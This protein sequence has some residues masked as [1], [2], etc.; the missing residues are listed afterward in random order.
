M[1]RFVYL[2]PLP[3]PPPANFHSTQQVA[4]GTQ[5][6]NSFRKNHLCSGNTP[7]RHIPDFNRRAR[8]DL[9]SCRTTPSTVTPRT[10]PR[11]N[12]RIGRT[13][14]DTPDTRRA[15]LLILVPT[16]KAPRPSRS[17]AH[18]TTLTYNETSPARCRHQSVWAS[19]P[20]A[21]TGFRGR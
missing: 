12:L 13:I 1:D 7:A 8:P 17:I 2:H 4:S 9:E 10:S 15:S 6:H 21:A 16:S 20:A 19:T 11:A 18:T 5:R 14:R 3:P